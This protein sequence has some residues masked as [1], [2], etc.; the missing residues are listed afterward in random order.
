VTM[1]IVK[2]LEFPS[3]VDV[4]TS[5]RRIADQID[6]C[7]L[8]NVRFAG[9]VL[10]CGETEMALFSLGKHTVLE[11]AGAFTWA[12]IAASQCYKLRDA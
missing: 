11:I 12:S 10:D 7:E 8:G 9:V 1:T 4:P 5:L 6:A 3:A 2:P